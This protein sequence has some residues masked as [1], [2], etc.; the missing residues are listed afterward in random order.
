MYF[1][2]Q[3]VRSTSFSQDRG[4]DR[5]NLE[6]RGDAGVYLMPEK[7]KKTNGNNIL[8]SNSGLRITTLMAQ[9]PREMVGLNLLTFKPTT[10][11]STTEDFANE[12]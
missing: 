12:R 7:A 5:A 4:Q 11:T 3:V 1:A 10:T 9:K 8:L 2:S 6:H